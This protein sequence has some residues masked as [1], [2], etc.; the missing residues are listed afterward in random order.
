VPKDPK[1]IKK[2]FESLRV[3]RS[4]WESI[5][6]EVAD[7]GLGRRTFTSPVTSTGEG[8]RTRYIFDNTMMVANDLL[9]SGLHNLLTSTAN[10]WMHLEPDDPRIMELPGAADWY[11]VAE[12]ALFAAIERPEAGFHPQISECYNDLAG[13]GNCA[14]AT[15]RNRNVGLWFQAMPLAETYVDEGPDGRIQSIYRFWRYTP[16]QFRARWPEGTSEQVDAKFRG[17]QTE[18][19]I[20][21]LQC[22]IPNEIFEEGVRFG[23][24]ASR[25]KSI[26]M[27]Y[28]DAEVIEEKFFREMPIAFS[29]WNLD[30]GELYGRGPGVQ[31]L[32]EARMLNEMNK[33]MLE[34]AQKAVN[35]PLL[36]P[37]N[38][39]VTQL[40]ISPGGL[41]V[42]RAATQDPVRELYSR[43]SS[44]ADLGQDQIQ[45]RQTNVR[46]AYHFDLLSIIQDPRMSAT[47]VLEISARTQQILSPLVGRVQH[48][49]LEP[50]T[51]RSFNIG[52]RAGWIPPPPAFLRGSRVNIRYVSPV[53]RAQRAQEAAKL[54]EAINGVMQLGQLDPSALDTLDS[55]AISRFMF[56]AQGVPA[57][58]LRSPEAVQAI[59]QARA[60]QAQQQEQFQMVNEGARTAMPLLTQL[61]GQ[62][63]Q[64]EGTQ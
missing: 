23:P 29:R 38:G 43:P 58:L 52:L 56:D 7:H 44:G 39:F 21:I 3:D 50:I 17:V 54:V 63:V 2:Q 30:P 59:R 33:T 51:E 41:S 9:A 26:T 31:A 42:F 8:K 1:Q 46:A 12:D 40:D 19:S 16:A 5:W 13:F 18:R 20:E 49:L 45:A 36:V 61:A 60:Q 64:N 37:D 14:M 53:Q 27:M 11:A 24:R 32:S 55:D 4:T 25:I 57:H 47:Q 10:R 6:Q 22:F 15:L 62:N 28:N 35:P 34:G 48:D